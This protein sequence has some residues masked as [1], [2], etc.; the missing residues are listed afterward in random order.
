MSAVA[1]NRACILEE[2]QVLVEEL[3]ES[4]K[5]TQ[6]LRERAAKKNGQLAASS[7]AA[8]EYSMRCK[9]I[10][11]EHDRRIEELREDRLHL[12]SSL[13]ALK[14]ALH[15]IIISINNNSSINNTGVFN[16]KAVEDITREEVYLS[17]KMEGLAKEEAA[18]GVEMGEMR[19]EALTLQRA[20]YLQDA[21]HL[22]EVE[23]KARA[24]HIMV[25]SS[26]GLQRDAHD[27]HVTPNP[28]PNPLPITTTQK[29]TV[30]SL[31]DANK[32]VLITSAYGRPR[33][34]H[35]PG[36]KTR[37]ITTATTAAT[38]ATT[39]HPKKA[40]TTA[41]TATTIVNSKGAGGGLG[42]GERATNKG[43]KGQR[44]ANTYT[45]TKAN[46]NTNTD[47]FSSVAKSIRER[48]NSSPKV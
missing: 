5:R 33:S 29:K 26:G 38:T 18:L 19:K 9:G 34:G 37:P 23:S 44:R 2:K 25:S 31:S 11:I 14:A 6:R 28:L 39:P 36:P 21:S 10:I 42:R 4:V 45:N 8:V 48:L 41:T 1:E 27:H 24:H 13:S 22:S 12:D 20:V 35:Q 32:G 7:R 46:T 16:E 47:E 43:T 15:G 3:G 17:E 40:A 30:A